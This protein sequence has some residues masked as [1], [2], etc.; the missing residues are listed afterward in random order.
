MDET[1]VSQPGARFQSTRKIDPRAHTK[2]K[3]ETVR[4]AL[5]W[6]CEIPGSTVHTASVTAPPA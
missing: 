3:A 4:R 5:R 6:T 1:C 2:E